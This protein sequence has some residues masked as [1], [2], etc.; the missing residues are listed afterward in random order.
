MVSHSF[1]ESDNRIIRYAEALAERGDEVVVLALGRPPGLP[2]TEVINGVTLHRI[3]NRHAKK[4]GGAWSYL[5][6]LLRFVLAATVWFVRHGLRRPFTLVH[7]HNIPDFLVVAALVPRLRGAKVIL[8]IHDIVPEFFA[9]K[10]GGKLT[11]KMNA[12]LL[13][14][15]RVSA[16]MAHHVILSN[17]LW[18][19]TYTQRAAPA[20]K[21]SVFINHVDETIF[22]A[23]DAVLSRGAS[24]SDASSTA[25]A[26]ATTTADKP[27]STL[28]NPLII[29]PG[30]LYEHQGVDIAVR[31]VDALRR[32]VP[33]IRFHIY[34]EG[35][36]KASLQALVASLGLQEH[37]RFFAPMPL[38]RIAE[39]MATADIAVVP[40]RADSFGNEAYSTKIMEFMSLGV[41]V[42]VSNTRV[43]RHYFDPSVVRFFASGDAQALADAVTYL[44]DHPQERAAMV[45]RASSYVA[46]HNWSRHKLDYLRLVDSLVREAPRPLAQSLDV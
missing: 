27:T 34:G 14:M 9:S 2:A 46:R 37:V 23:P 35:S 5:W 13:L 26:D 33:G 10:F 28:T 3:Q 21:C 7:V 12:A 41:P 4:D 11:P 18:L 36:A 1:Y 29:F 44:L 25:T 22:R 45:Q 15:E 17:H 42:V 8:D 19:Q 40:K 43:D 30:G 38:R 20:A 24:V 32:S 16:A 31:A 39:V 6:P